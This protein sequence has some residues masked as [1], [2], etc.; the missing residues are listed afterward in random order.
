MNF[1]LQEGSNVIVVWDGLL[2]LTY[3]DVL[4]CFFF[5]TFSFLGIFCIDWEVSC[6]F[7]GHQV[8]M[9]KLLMPEI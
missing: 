7:L 9:D 4:P 8:N 5:L 6:L 2:G 3:G 1:N